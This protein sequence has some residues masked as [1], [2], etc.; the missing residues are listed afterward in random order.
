MA[1][2]AGRPLISQLRG[3]HFQ[4]FPELEIGYYPVSVPPWEVYNGDYFAKYEGYASTELGRILTSLRLELVRRHYHGPLLDVGIGSGDFVAARNGTWGFD[5]NPAAVT[6]LNDRGLFADPYQE[7]FA[8]ASF[9]D[10]LEHIADFP[11]IL[12]RVREWAFMSLPIFDGPDDVLR[13]KHY[14]KDEHCWYF[15]ERGLIGLMARFGWAVAEVSNRETMAG[16]WAIKSFAF[17]RE[18]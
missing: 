3:A 10:S 13:S 4:W 11:R 6:W 7:S 1:R 17:K 9:W 2:E 14:R 15:T 5:I 16:R 8:S 12:A 18:G